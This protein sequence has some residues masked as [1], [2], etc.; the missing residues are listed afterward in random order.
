MSEEF[1]I[2]SDIEHV[3]LR[4][5][6]YIG[7]I[8]NESVERFIYGKY[9]EFQYVPGLVKIIEEV[10][11]NSVDEAIR[12]NFK[13]ANIINVVIDKKSV[14]ITDNGRGIPHDLIKTPEGNEIPKAVAA[15]T[16]T[17]AGSNFEDEGRVTGGMNGVGS[18]LTNIFSSK[19]VGETCDGKNVLTVSCSNNLSN[20]EYHSKPK[21]MAGTSVTFE[22][23]F[24]I[25][26]CDDISDTVI[27]IIH[28]RILALSVV[29]PK[30]KFVFNGSIVNSSFK[31]YSKM[32]GEGIVLETKNG[33]IGIT[34]SDD[35]FRQVSY[36]NGLHTKNGGSHVDWLTDELTTE[37]IPQIKRKYKVDVTRA[38]IKE[39]MTLVFIVS[40]MTN[41]KFDSQTKE[42]LTNTWG[43][44]K[45]HLDIDI[46]KLSKL[47]LDSDEI[48]IP[49]IEAALIRKEA[50]EKAA[51]TRAQRAASKAK[52]AKHIK[53]N[54]SGKQ[55]GTTLFISEGLSA[56]GYLLSVRDSDLH[57][58]YP[59][60]GKVLNT[61][62]KPE[63]EIVKNQEIFDLLAITG[64]RFGE[65]PFEYVEDDEWVTVIHDSLGTSPVTLNLNDDVY[66]KSTNTWIPVSILEY[67]SSTKPKSDYHKHPLIRKKIKTDNILYTNIAIM[68]DADIDG[69]GSIFPAL[70]ALF[71]NWPSLFKHG[72][73]KFVMTP[74][75]I[76]TKGKDIKWF[77]SIE[78]YEQSKLNSYTI[79]YIKGLGSLEEDEYSKIINEPRFETVHLPENYIELFEILLG[80][81]ADLRKDWMKQ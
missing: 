1:K 60:R 20:M 14:T 32:Y 78:E 81:N 70:L 47:V 59:L 13:F 69:K 64:L 77:Y 7:S 28:D 5:G 33:S 29:F 46:K 56:I 55:D 38:R 27:N 68:V 6:M 57:G 44:V 65:E 23:D 30:I 34:S 58:G 3:K 36:V 19:F 21:K 40:N 45:S 41:L 52:V 62:G 22:P 31:N 50:A 26:E 71:S 72:R 42:R 54:K 80:S 79:R 74:I 43:E 2:L 10:L 63:A 39:C 12:T 53:A 11:D 75:V 24:K 48:I 67:Q 25:F 66:C 61:W 73:I 49:I 4:P 51:L 76:A 15:W 18:S 35:G 9:G 8:S 16:R 37:L 17:K